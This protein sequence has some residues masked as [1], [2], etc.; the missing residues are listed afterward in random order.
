M[1]SWPPLIG[2]IISPEINLLLSLWSSCRGCR[3]LFSCKIKSPFCRNHNLP[4]FITGGSSVVVMLNRWHTCQIN[5]VKFGLLVAQLRLG[6]GLAI[7]DWVSSR[8][9]HKSG[10]CVLE[11][12]PYLVGASRL[13]W[14]SDFM[15]WTIAFDLELPATSEC[16]VGELRC[17]SLSNWCLIIVVETCHWLMVVS[18]FLVN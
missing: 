8:S 6:V 4:L 14:C 3:L 2:D 5:W 1:D 16:V 18:R 11:M 17:W 15:E 10:W 12:E 13:S 9:S 7:L